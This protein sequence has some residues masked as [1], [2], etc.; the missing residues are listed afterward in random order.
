MSQVAVVAAITW[1]DGRYSARCLGVRDIAGRGENM[2]DAVLE[3]AEK[4]SRH[5][6]AGG[7]PAARPDRSVLW[8]PLPVEM[9]T[10]LDVTVN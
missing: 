1:E 7:S 10:A 4:L 5:F 9:L 2:V 3:L 8:Q 6:A